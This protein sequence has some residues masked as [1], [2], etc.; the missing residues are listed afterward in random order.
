VQELIIKA[1][2]TNDENKTKQEQYAE[3]QWAVDTA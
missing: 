1:P 2:K 3:E